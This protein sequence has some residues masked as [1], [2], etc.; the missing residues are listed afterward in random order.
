MEWAAVFLV[1]EQLEVFAKFCP[2]LRE[3][4]KAVWEPVVRSERNN[5]LDPVR[6]GR[7]PRMGR[8]DC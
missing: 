8:S 6:I 7:L 2:R 5:G 3:I 1:L 4:M